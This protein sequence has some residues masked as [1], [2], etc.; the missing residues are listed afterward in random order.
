MSKSASQAGG[1]AAEVKSVCAF[2]SPRKLIF[3]EC[4]ERATGVCLAPPGWTSLRCREPGTEGCLVRGLHPTPL[5]CAG[6]GLRFPR[7]GRL[8]LPR[9]AVYC[10]TAKVVG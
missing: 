7:D 2:G 8:L 6:V 4:V 1:L 3:T 5:C 9:S 10:R